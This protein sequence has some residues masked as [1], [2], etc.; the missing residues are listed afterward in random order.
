MNNYKFFFVVRSIFKAF[1]KFFLTIYTT[2]VPPS[3]SNFIKPGNRPQSSMSP[4]IVVENLNGRKTLKMVAGASGGTRI[5]TGT[6]LV[7]DNFCTRHFLIP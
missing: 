6:A 2:G 5:T 7:C 3:P 4:A 1:Y